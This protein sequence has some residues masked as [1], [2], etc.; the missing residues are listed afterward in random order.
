MYL[1][2]FVFVLLVTQM[3]LIDDTIKYYR[4]NCI[5]IWCN[6]GGQNKS[7]YE[8]IFKLT[9]GRLFKSQTLWK[10]KVPGEI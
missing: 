5:C 3:C 7:Q 8:I 4:N 6:G 10:Y 1:R 9:I 2:I